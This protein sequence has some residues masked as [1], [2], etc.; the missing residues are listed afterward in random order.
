MI[1]IDGIINYIKKAADKIN[2]NIDRGDAIPF[3]SQSEKI[4]E[5]IVKEEKEVLFRPHRGTLAT[6][7]EEVRAF[8]SRAEL[9]DFLNKDLANYGR[10]IDENKFR[11]E[12][13]CYDERIGWDTY[14]V[15][16]E[17]YGVF[18]FTNGLLL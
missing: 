4:I 8:K 3:G 16:Q 1:N 2:K 9:I 6:A 17:G 14:I 12:P 10:K 18:G 15:D 7:M 11:I 13:Y 5:Y